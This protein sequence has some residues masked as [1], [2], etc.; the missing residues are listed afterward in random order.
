MVKKAWREFFDEAFLARLERLRLV[1]KSALFRARGGARRS[2]RVGDGLEFAD[3][4]AYAPGDDIRFIDWACY[5]R[6]DRLLLRLFHEH[7]ESDVGIVLDCSASMAPGGH[8]EKFNAARRSAAAL[9]YIA[10]AGGERVRLAPF[11][12]ELGEPLR[13]ARDRGRFFRVLDWLAGL[14]PGGRT[15]LKHCLERFVRGGG[16]VSTVLLVSDLLDCREELSDALAWLRAAGAGACV[17]HLVSPAD[18]DPPL[19]GPLLLQQAETGR[20]L[21]LEVTPPV[22]DSYRARWGEFAGFCRRTCLARGALYV[23]ARTDLP[24]DRGLLSALRQAGALQ[25]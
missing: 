11:A 16:S 23:P 14:Q 3:H 4:R 7:G 24:M 13:T 18:A 21:S 20:R 5:A 22:R 9:S 15:R 2:R 8:R 19:A 17:V 12:E 10:M 1:A 25:G 6:M